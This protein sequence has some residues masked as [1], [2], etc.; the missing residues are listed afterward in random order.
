MN[1]VVKFLGAS[2]IAGLVGF[3]ATVFADGE[4][5]Y[6]TQCFACHDMGVAGAPKLTDKENWAPRIAQGVDTL[7]KHAIEGFTGSAGVMPPRGGSQFSDDEI[8]EI[9]DYMV[10]QAGS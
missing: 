3:S 8:K 7:Y 2:V 10:E 9:V 1:P 5:K 6:K 4:A